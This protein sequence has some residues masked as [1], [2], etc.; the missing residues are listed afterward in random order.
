METK[1]KR[2]V[3]RARSHAHR[4]AEQDVVYTQPKPFNRTRFLLQLAT[5]GAVVIAVLFGMSIFFKVKNVQSYYDNVFRY[6]IFK[7]NN[8]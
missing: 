8:C 1:E 2:K 3:A 6:F 5:V 4:K 7:R